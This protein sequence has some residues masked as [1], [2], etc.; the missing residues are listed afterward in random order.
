MLAQGPLGTWQ[1]G[2]GM[3][4]RKTQEN[5]LIILSNRGTLCQHPRESPLFDP[6]LLC[7]TSAPLIDSLTCP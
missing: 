3:Q 5:Y 4:G 2:H 1:G 7:L 6:V